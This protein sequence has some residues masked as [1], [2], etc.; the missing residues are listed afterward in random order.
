MTPGSIVPQR[1]PII[2]PSSVET[3]IVVAMLSPS[4]TGA[5]ETRPVRRRDPTAVLYARVSTPEQERDGLSIP[6]QV[7]LLRDYAQQHGITIVR[8]FIDVETSARAGRTAFG[9]IMVAALLPLNPVVTLVDAWGAG[10]FL[11]SVLS[12][13]AVRV[14]CQ[15]RGH[16]RSTVRLIDASARSRELRVLST[17]T[18]RRIEPLS[19]VSPPCCEPLIVSK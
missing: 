4:R 9:N 16:D 15:L 8:K 14:R 17:T 11:E 1:V 5:P 3:L 2:R 10:S 13:V 7:Q 19:P 12:N 6:A 18:F